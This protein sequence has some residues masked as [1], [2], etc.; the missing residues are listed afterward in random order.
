M[1]V[2]GLAAGTLERDDKYHAHDDNL[3]QVDG[4]STY[5]RESCTCDIQ[6]QLASH[7]DELRIRFECVLV[8]PRM[9]PASLFGNGVLLQR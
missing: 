8:P 4:I 7:A 1:S 9:E 6:S 2:T 5:G 3:W